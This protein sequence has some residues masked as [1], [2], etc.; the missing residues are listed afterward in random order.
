M[1]ALPLDLVD[2]YVQQP[3]LYHTDQC[4][5][6]KPAKEKICFLLEKQ[7]SS[8]FYFIPIN[9]KKKKRSE[10]VSGRSQTLIIGHLQ[11]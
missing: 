8:N 6:P 11:T 3:A 10:V 9:L 4:N 2:E 7:N 5:A 1:F